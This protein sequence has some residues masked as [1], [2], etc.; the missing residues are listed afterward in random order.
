[1]TIIFKT[2]KNAA[3]SPVS[4]HIVLW[5]LCLLTAAGIYCL[6]T[7][8]SFAEGTADERADC[9]SDAMSIC[10]QFIPD[11]RAITACMIKNKAKLSPACRRHFK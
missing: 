5:S 6:A 9:M 7:T 10:G 4:A 1:M 11:T 8:A 3:R 2:I